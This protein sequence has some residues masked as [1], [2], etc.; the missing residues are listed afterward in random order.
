MIHH[1][2]AEAGPYP[3][4]LIGKIDAYGV[5][6]GIRG[7]FHNRIRVIIHHAPQSRYTRNE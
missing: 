4:C 3:I 5:W 7:A 2:R 6:Q 1:G